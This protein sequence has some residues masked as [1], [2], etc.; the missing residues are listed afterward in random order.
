M[1]RDGFISYSHQRDV[2]LAQAL[3]RGLHKL[4][5]PWTRR[6]VINVFRDTTSLSAN[7][8]LW[9]SI[10]QELE[11][12]RY[13]IYLA[14]P[15]AAASRWVQKEIDFWLNNRP[16]DRFLIA[17]SAGTVVWDHRA[18][19]FDWS[20]T[21]ALPPLLRGRF[22]AEPLWVDLAAVRK[23]EKYS[24][25]QADFRDA[26]ATLAAPLHGRS[27]DQLDS[28]DIRQHRVATRMRR[29]AVTGLAILLVT[30]LAAGGF[31]WQQRGEAL[32]RARVSASQALAARSL[33]IAD[34]DPRKAAQFALYA[35]EVRPT[36]ESAQALARAVEANRG[37]V[38]HLQG[39]F[40]AVADYRGA[41]NQPATQVAISR[42]GSTLAYYSDLGSAPTFGKG[43]DEVHIYDIRTGKERGG[44]P[45]GGWAQSGGALALSSDGR[46]LII[47]GARNTIEIWSV[48]DRKLLRT[49]TASDTEDL[50]QVARRLRAWALSGDGRWMAATYYAAEVKEL[51]LSV[52]DTRTGVLVHRGAADS[53]EI[54][55][56]FDKD[57]RRL[58]A[59]DGVGGVARAYDLK[60]RRWGSGR[61]LPGLPLKGSSVTFPSGAADRALLVSGGNPEDEPE[62]EPGRKTADG[63]WDLAQ[64]KRLATTTGGLNYAALPADNPRI[65]VAAEEKRVSVFD[66]RLRRQRVLG[67]FGWP[68]MSV[69]T[70]GDGQWVAAGSSDGA[71][72]LFTVGARGTDDLPNE[73]RLT[74]GELT[75]DGRLAYGVGPGHQDETEL[76]AVADGNAGLRRLGRIPE[77]VPLSDG[78]VAATPDGGRVALFSRGELSLWDPRTGRQVGERRTY[79]YRTASVNGPRLYFLADGVHLV[80]TW[81]EKVVLIDTRTGVLKQVLDQEDG[82]TLQLALSGDRKTLVAGD[83]SLGDVLVWRWSGDGRFEKVR[84]V[85]G[86]AESGV[87]R[88]S[89]DHG[90]RKVAT[91]NADGRIA[92]L[93]VGT[94]RAVTSPVVTRTGLPDVVFSGDARTLVHAFA[95]TTESGLEF[96]DTESGDALGSW[97]LGS[98]SPAAED[99]SP[100][101]VPA[102]G[103][104][105]LVLGSDG[106]LVRRPLDV[107]DWRETLCGLVAEPLP[108]GERDRYLSDLSIDAPCSGD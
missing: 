66:S 41:G 36:G 29:G 106:T 58:M 81:D 38:R 16:M 68:V 18:D 46:L 93:D 67:S 61:E 91:V 65:V 39:G 24:L 19:D 40:E 7:H 56:A 64:G 101:V 75:P 2:E 70:S 72:S 74:A 51:Q 86:R 59:F 15:E 4:A 99:P 80:G 100:Q 17:V 11:R 42:D 32:E 30:S 63:L 69:A 79:A 85:D 25:R 37:V 49:L 53:E 92:V 104:G 73:G 78:A 27:K 98:H 47:E 23:G 96:W 88:I 62:D 33:E 44:L 5:R 14:S 60:T 94:G 71:V 52:W 1:T 21:D 82:G 50:A 90:G 107:A 97:I 83:V 22:E 8:D 54:H 57:D 55:L 84:K 95:T 28:E 20:R 108:K 102:P 3:Q 105:V 12:S 45:T 48:P 89:V 31:A 77:G 43:P 103:G 34:T 35:E 76:W 87:F 10:L 26:V 13:F 9:S 6:Q